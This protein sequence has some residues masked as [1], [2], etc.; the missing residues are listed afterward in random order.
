MA[1]VQLKDVRVSFVNG[2]GGGFK[3]EEVNESRGKTYKTRFSVWPTTD[4][5]VQVGDVISLSGFLSAKVGDPWE[6]SDGQ[7]RYSV[8]LS[9]NSPRIDKPK[10]AADQAMALVDEPWAVAADSYND[11]TPF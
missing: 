10:P 2:R 8:E 1:I 9:V 5:G 6:G 3:V 4:A 11:E 7:P